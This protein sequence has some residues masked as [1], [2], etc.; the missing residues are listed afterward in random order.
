MNEMHKMKR[1]QSSIEYI[2][3]YGWVL[4][5]LILVVV[6]MWNAGFFKLSTYSCSKNEVMQLNTVRIT[7]IKFLSSGAVYMT[8]KNNEE[9]SIALSSVKINGFAPTGLSPSLPR[10]IAVGGEVNFTGTVASLAGAVGD[11]KSNIPIEFVYN[12]TGGAS[13]HRDA[14][15]MCFRIEVG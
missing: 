13:G 5:I 12:L 1:G 14:G 15:V 6:G 9:A 4:L 2:V 10:T 3:T 7:A 8:V 11:T